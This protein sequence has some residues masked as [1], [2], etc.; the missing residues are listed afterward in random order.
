MAKT[1]RRLTGHG[2]VRSHPARRYSDR[3]LPDSFT[4]VTSR[5]Q[6]GEKMRKLIL[7]AD[8]APSRLVGVIEPADIR[9]DHRLERM[10]DRDPAEVQDGPATLGEAQDGRSIGYIGQGKPCAGRERV[11]KGREVGK[12]QRPAAP[13]KRFRKHPP[14]RARGAG[15]RPNRAR[16]KCRRCRAGQSRRSARKFQR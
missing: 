9:P 13:G 10:L 3:L 4:E 7:V 14:Q 16:T 12:P 11:R 1:L 8:L 6:Y 15:R 2:L 5:R